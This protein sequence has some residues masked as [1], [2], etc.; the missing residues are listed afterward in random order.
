M[1]EDR[2]YATG[3]RKNAIARV[4]IKPGNGS[5]VV[6]ER[7]LDT[8]FG[9]QTSRMVILQPFELTQTVG[10]FDLVASVHGGGLSGQAGA[11]KHGL[12][13]ALL[14]VDPSFRS[15]LKSAGFLTRDSR[16]KERKKYGKRAAR[17]SF[18][19]SKR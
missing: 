13:K 10:R 12:S 19:F 16:V 14:S 2:F 1:S 18:Q 9:R 5:I 6:N 15:I 11:I 17:A 7:P 8:Y 4:W 3:K